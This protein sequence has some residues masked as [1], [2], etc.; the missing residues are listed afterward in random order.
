MADDAATVE[1][2]RAEARQL[3]EQ[4][5]VD[6]A[7]IAGLRQREAALA[8]ETITLR[9]ANAALVVERAE[10]I[11][12]QSA[13]SDILRVIAAYPTDVQ[14]VLETVAATAARLCDAGDA[15]IFRREGA[16]A[17]RVVSYGPMP[18]SLGEVVPISRG[19][20]VG[21]AMLDCRTIHVPDLAVEIDVQYPEVR[22]IQRRDHVRTV[23]VT[24]LVRGETAIGAILIRRSEVRPFTEQQIRLL[25]TFADQAAI[26]IE[27]ARLFEELERRNAELSESLEQQAGTAEI[28]RVIATSPTDARP[29]LDAIVESASRLSHSPRAALYTTVDGEESQLE[30][31]AVFGQAAYGIWEGTVGQRYTPLE[32][33]GTAS[34]RGGA[35]RAIET[36][37]TVHLQDMS[38]PEVVA[39]YPHI[40]GTAARLYVPLVHEQQAV[41]VLIL[42]RDVA[43]PYSPREI[44]LM[45][46]FAD[47]AVIAIE[48]ARLF[49]ELEHRNQELSEALEREQATG[50]ILRVLATS[51]A[52]LQ[53]VLETVARS[54]ARLCGANG[55]NI[56]RVDGDRLRLATNLPYDGLFTEWTAGLEGGMRLSRDTVTARSVVDRRTV[57]VHD[58]AAESDDEYPEGKILSRRLGHRTTLATPLL[59]KG[60]PLGAIIIRRAEVRPFTDDQIAL[61]ETFANQAAIAIENARLFQE[62]QE[63]V[64]ELQALGEV[65]RTVSSSLDLAEVLTTIVTN[66][67]RLCRVEAGIVYEYDERDQSFSL[68]AAHQVP[69]ELIASLIARPP[70]LGGGALGGSAASRAPVQVEEIAGEDGAR[71][72][73]SA[74]REIFIRYG[75]GSLI[76]VPLLRQDDLLGVILLARTRTGA[77]PDEIVA[78]LKT[79]AAQSAL[80]IHNARLFRALEQQSHALEEASQ[81]KSQFL[82]NMR[83]ELRTPLNAIIGY[84]E[85][86][87]EEGE[88]TEADA[89]LPDL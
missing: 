76:A 84:S 38:A 83:H 77:F 37:C 47:Q 39:E 69:D 54:A 86:L 63:R 85:M 27:N 29:V 36:R 71:H 64:G 41:G 31:V 62:L 46:T 23:L 72:L 10:A 18:P 20:P 7:E 57:H 58:L 4:R 13:T 55:A 65:G 5:S 81:H 49:D 22:E 24:P 52:D 66:V 21:R 19:L 60:E 2:L 50:E 25:E 56:W 6:Q 14:A 28:L 16:G 67:T 8:T 88:E 48:N 89:F 75:F 9:T 82:A 79:F 74:N 26:A 68:R 42:T 12:Q 53:V 73:Q 51:P 87:Q 32:A 80:A 44:R 33:P 40:R 3:R 70:R 17:R 11:A 35:L 59:A 30:C 43:R 45:E 78:L 61:L 15:V 1:Q 34:R